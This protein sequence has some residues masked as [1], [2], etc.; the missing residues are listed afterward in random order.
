MANRPSLVRIAF[1]AVLICGWLF[2]STFATSLAIAADTP[3]AKKADDKAHGKAAEETNVH[4]PHGKPDHPAADVH[5]PHEKVNPSPIDWKT[6]LNLWTFV[7]FGVFLVVLRVF[8]WGPLTSALDAREAKI[9]GNLAHAEEAREKAERLLA[10]YQ[11]QLAAAQDQI[12]KMMAEARRDG[13]HTRQQILAQTE[14]DV[15]LLKD[16]AVAEIE[17]TRDSAL[18]ELFG[19][20][21]GTV[22]NATEKVLGRALTDSDQDRLVNEALVEFSRQQAS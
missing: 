15:A 17:Q 10:D 12:Q 20:M 4:A 8:A 21:A 3:A 14:R 7:V 11:T 18:N 19:H 5:D 16:R 22:A 9:H 6:D 1:T 13:E 2:G